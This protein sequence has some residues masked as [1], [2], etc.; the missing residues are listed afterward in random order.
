MSGQKKL[1][2][3]S[4]LQNEIVYY[5]SKFLLKSAKNLFNGKFSRE[6]AFGERETTTP[7]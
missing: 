1:I 4:V 7:I 6:M 3:K 5:F 2:Q